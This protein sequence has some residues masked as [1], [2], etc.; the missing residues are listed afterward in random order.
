[1]ST[2]I[3]AHS[4]KIVLELLLAYHRNKTNKYPVPARNPLGISH[5]AHEMSRFADISGEKD[6]IR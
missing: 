4:T 1:M 5:I 6:Q 3:G 2:H